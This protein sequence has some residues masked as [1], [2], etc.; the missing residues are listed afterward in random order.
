MLHGGVW[1]GSSSQFL[2]P[3]NLQMDPAHSVYDAQSINYASI[4]LVVLL[5]FIFWMYSLHFRLL[6][7]KFYLIF[8]IPA[9]CSCVTVF[10]RTLSLSLCLCSLQWLLKFY[11]ILFY[12]M[13][14]STITAAKQHYYCPSVV[15]IAHPADN[16]RLS[17]LAWVAGYTP[18]PYN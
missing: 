18:R 17:E 15:L 10:Y 9:L 5:C 11:L 3:L 2:R 14:D 13:W 7:S 1:V 4:V 16:T 6:S 8:I 12:L